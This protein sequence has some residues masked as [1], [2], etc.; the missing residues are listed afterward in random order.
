MAEVDGFADVQLHLGEALGS[1]RVERHPGRCATLDLPFAEIPSAR[2]GA[3]LSDDEAVHQL[4]G[5]VGDLCNGLVKDRL[6]VFC[7]F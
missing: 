3:L 2:L 5:C 7:R 4:L 1:I 6:I